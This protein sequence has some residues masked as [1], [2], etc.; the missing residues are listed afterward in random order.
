MNTV[1]KSNKYAIIYRNERYVTVMDSQA[2]RERN[3]YGAEI[4]HRDLTVSQ[5]T[6]WEYYYNNQTPNTD[7]LK[8]LFCYDYNDEQ[9][10]G[11]TEFDIV[12]VRCRDGIWR[13]GSVVTWKHDTVWIEVGSLIYRADMEGAELVATAD[14]DEWDL[15]DDAEYNALLDE[16]T[17]DE[18]EVQTLSGVAA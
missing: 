13:T 12:N 1:K 5:A 3:L 4:K 11:I 7:C 2:T 17:G 6:E 10:N 9:E 18:Y 14:T 16:I 8:G 15:A